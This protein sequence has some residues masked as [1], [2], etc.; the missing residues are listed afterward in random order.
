[1]IPVNRLSGTPRPFQRAGIN[2]V[3]R[4]SLKP[5]GQKVKLP[6]STFGNITIAGSLKD[7][8]TVSQRLAVPHYVKICH[9]ITPLYYNPPFPQKQ[10]PRR[11]FLTEEP[12]NERSLLRF[13]KFKI[14]VVKKDKIQYNLNYK[15]QKGTVPCPKAATKKSGSFIS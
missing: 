1:M 8:G 6:L 9:K 10:P 7:A 3:K 13:F 12:T 14:T 4:D 15:K 5:L 11:I 2:R